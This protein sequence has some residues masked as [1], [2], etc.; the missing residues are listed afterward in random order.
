MLTGRGVQADLVVAT[1][2]SAGSHDLSRTESG[3]RWSG[4]DGI[5]SLAELLGMSERVELD[6]QELGSVGVT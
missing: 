3:Q 1:D 4:H 5:G 2:G 6:Q